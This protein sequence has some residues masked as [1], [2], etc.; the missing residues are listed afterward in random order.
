MSEMDDLAGL[1]A[2]YSAIRSGDADSV[3]ALI[4]EEPQRLHV[5]TVFGSWLHV[6]SFAGQFEIVKLLVALGASID[7]R[8]G[9]MGGAPI[10]EAAAKGHL[11]IVRFLVAHGAELDVGEPERNPLF[12]AIYGGYDETVRFLLQSRINY[13]VKYTGDSMKNMGALEFALER[14]QM[15]IASILSNWEVQSAPEP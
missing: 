2:I 15:D 8:G 3:A 14:G 4:S 5:D 9:A 12:S 7:H 1:K 13:R 11:E 6:A 10:N